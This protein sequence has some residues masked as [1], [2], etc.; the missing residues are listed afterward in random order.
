MSKFYIENINLLNSEKKNN[1]LSEL[2]LLLS[3]YSAEERISWALSHLPHTQIMSSSFGIQSTVLLHLII[4]KKPD[5]PVVLIDTGYLFPETYNFIDFLTNKFHLNLKVFRSTISS[6]WQEARYGK[7]WEKG[8]EGIDFYNNI[9]KVQ[10]MNFALNEL[11]VQTWFAGLR[12]DQSK[13]RNLLPYLSIKK[14]IF[15]ILPILDWSKDKIKDYLKENNLDT[16]PLY[17]N[18]YSSVGDTH[19]TKKHMP[20]MLEEETRFF[21]LKRECGLHE[22]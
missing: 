4:K 21:G 11:S 3:N 13:S 2:N 8:I 5:I 19:T 9:N 14:G 16:H 18:G 1:I 7:L 22:N 20:G 12:R 6:A 17:N 10:P 15:K